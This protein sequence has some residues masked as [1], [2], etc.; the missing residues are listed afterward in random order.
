M[1]KKEIQPKPVN[2]LPL[3]HQMVLGG[4]VDMMPL[5]HW[6]KYKL[7]RRPADESSKF[8]RTHDR[9]QSRDIQVIGP[10]T[11]AQMI[12]ILQKEVASGNMMG[13]SIRE[14][15]N[16]NHPLW[17]KFWFTRWLVTPIPGSWYVTFGHVTCPVCPE[18]NEEKAYRRPQGR[19][20]LFTLKCQILVR[21]LFPFFQDSYS[22]VSYDP[23][24]T[25]REHLKQ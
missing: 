21:R 17:K 22:L 15:R 11:E 1:P 5:G 25:L 23:K 4:T 8:C 10:I 9:R 14:P 24:K 7:P 6:P 19:L 18:K 16:S 20:G 3:H 2:Q 13:I 12:E